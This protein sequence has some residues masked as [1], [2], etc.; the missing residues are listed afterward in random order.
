MMRAA[1]ATTVLAV[2]LFTAHGVVAAQST[3]DRFQAT[4]R[5]LKSVRFSFE[6]AGIKGTLAAT[7]AGSYKVIT[8]DRTIMCNGKTIWNVDTHSKTIVINNYDAASQETSLNQIFFT[9]LGAYTPTVESESRSAGTSLIRL[10]APSQ[11]ATVHNIKT[12]DVL[13]TNDPMKIISITVN[14]GTTTTWKISNMQR[15]PQLPASTFAAPSTAGYTV[16]DLR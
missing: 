16:V 4:H 13:V 12:V 2:T 15:N 6:G 1:L 8:H 11:S 5:S 14:D 9:V 10:T 7:S 3:L